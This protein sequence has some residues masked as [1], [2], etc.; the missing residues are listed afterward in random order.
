V[1]SFQ[2]NCPAIGVTDVRAKAT[3]EREPGS[4][5]VKTAFGLTNAVHHMNRIE[6]MSKNGKEY[7]SETGHSTTQLVKDACA[8]IGGASRTGT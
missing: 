4:K 6:V 8:A 1:K 3:L 7:F 2:E 5:G